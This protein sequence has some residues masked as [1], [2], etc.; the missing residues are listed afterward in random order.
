MRYTV[1]I[2]FDGYDTELDIEAST[3]Q[4]AKEKASAFRQRYLAGL[5][6][7]GRQRSRP[8]PFTPQLLN[9]S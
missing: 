9:R 7:D 2:E 5:D 1:K 8:V 3:E 4:E 6:A